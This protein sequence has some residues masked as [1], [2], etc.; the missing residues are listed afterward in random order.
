MTYLAL[1]R[2]YRPLD[3]ENLTGQQHVVQALMHGL[4][5]N[6][7]HHAYLFTGTRGVGK[8]TLARILAKCFNCEQGPTATPCGQCAACIDIS[9]GRYADLIELD[10]ATNTSVNDV[11]QLLDSAIYGPTR[12]RYKVYVIDEVHML[13]NS[14][15][16]AM[17]KTLEEPPEHLK[18]IL[19]TTDPQKIPVTVLSRCLQLNLKPL[20][21]ALIVD[22]LA[23]IL[24]QEGIIAESGGLMLLA[25]AARG[26]LRDALSLLDQAIAHGAGQVSTDSVRQMLGVVEEDY[27]YRLLAAIFSQDAQTLLLEGD[28]LLAR[29]MMPDMIIQELAA[30]LTQIAIA[31]FSQDALSEDVN[32]QEI[33]TLARQIDAQTVQMLYQVCIYG[34]RD[35]VLAPDPAS[36][37]SMV[38]LRLLAFCTTE[39]INVGKRAESPAPDVPF[40]KAP[41]RLQPSQA[42]TV[43]EGPVTASRPI[44]GAVVAAQ[45]ARQISAQAS[46]QVTPSATAFPMPQAVEKQSFAEATSI[47]P[48]W[49]QLVEQMQLGGPA[50]MLAE[51]SEW[52][53]LTEDRLKLRLPKIHERKKTVFSVAALEDAVKKVLNKEKLKIIFT[54]E[55]TQKPTYAAIKQEQRAQEKQAQVDAIQSD[56]YA[57]DLARRFDATCD[58]ATIEGIID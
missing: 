37:F 6:K 2:K 47:P 45:T 35:L 7:L 52:V 21:V 43:S 9:Q 5:Q 18:F 26:S 17:L 31:Q 51:N 48:D 11:R 50:R 8:T 14:A 33:Q 42:K 36:G 1:A 4:S 39:E 27:L 53:D 25:K 3:F 41:E 34:A 40:K 44:E 54:L 29:A 38:L 15:F 13:S 12:G 24:A 56:P 57:Q 46:E 22:R 28:A 55:E 19:A 30:L 49:H 58:S 10:A 16:N 20:P 32:Q 23:F